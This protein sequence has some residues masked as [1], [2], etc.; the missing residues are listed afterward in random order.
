M[1]LRFGF[2]SLLSRLGKDEHGTIL[3]Q[4]TVYLVAVFGFIGLTLDGGRYLLLHNSLQDL[5]DAAALAGAAKLD[6]T[7][8]AITRATAAA[9]AMADNNPPRWYDVGGSTSIG[10]P[11]FYS[12][13]NPDTA[14]TS[15]KDAKYIKVTTDVTADGISKVV[16]TFLIAVGAVS[17]RASATA[18]AKATGSQCFATSMMLCNPSEPQTGSTGD[19]SSFNPPAGTEFIFSVAGNTGAF[20]PGVFNL[21]NT[22]EGSGSD[23]EIKKF[24]SQQ[25]PKFCFTGSI[26][27][28]QGQKTNATISG[29]NVRFDQQP[30]GNTSGMDLTPAP[31]TID[32][33]SNPINNG[34]GNCSKLN[35]VSAQSLPLPHDPSFTPPTMSQGGGQQGPGPL[36][37]DLQTYWS[38]H[39]PGPLPEGIT[40]RWQIYQLE[41]AETEDAGI[42]NTDAAEP[43]G[44]VCAPASTEAAPEFVADRRLLKVAVVDCRYWGV[45]GNA[46]NNIPLT[47]YADFFLIRPSD[48]NIY[49]EYVGKNQINGANSLL[50]LIVQLVR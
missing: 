43:H 39:H 45:H 19:T 31:I 5:A 7:S 1:K 25:R 40:T 38:N 3:M 18:M 42:W 27:P 50:R 48:G 6:G 20:S 9:Q 34:S 8:G 14:T 23:V 10:T 30:S 44:P 21:L 17:Q 33:Q 32:G 16:P 37:T 11:V 46:V 12:S 41:V 35:D 36:L 47:T 15:D 13:L 4:F 49:T 26:N 24:L 29:I 22:P 28:A 2:F